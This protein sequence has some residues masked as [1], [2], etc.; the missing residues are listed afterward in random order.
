MDWSLS[1]GAYN[2]IRSNLPD[3][4]TILELGSGAGSERLAQNYTVYSVEHDAAWV[5]R[6]SNVHYIHSPLREHKVVKGFDHNFWYTPSIIKEKIKDLKIDLII[7]DGPKG[8]HKMGES[9]RSGA[10]KYIDIFPEG[11]PFLFD[12]LHRGNELLLARKVSA[13]LK[14]PLTIYTWEPK[15]WGYIWNRNGKLNSH[16]I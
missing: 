12:D 7:I 10:L 4:A 2:W 5:N 14:S 15:Q 6:Y 16:T 3:G 8:G 13:R 9:G 1:D 11:V